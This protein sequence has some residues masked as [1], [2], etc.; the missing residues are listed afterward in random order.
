MTSTRYLGEESPETKYFFD[1][2]PERILAAAERFGVRCTGRVTQLNSMEN[3]VYEVEVELEAEPRTPSE[4]FR[5][6]KFY[7]PGRWSE[8]QILEEH[9]FLHDLQQAEIPAIA[10]T[11]AADGKTLL[12]FPDIKIWFSLFPKGGGRSPDELDDESTER[13]GRLLARMHTVGSGKDAPQRLRVT[14][15]VYGLQNV[16]YL[17]DSEVLPP[18][19]R[20]QYRAVVE[21]ICAF[22]EPL[23]KEVRPQRIHGDCHF[24]NILLGSLGMFL[25]DFDDMAVG[26]PVQDMWLLIPGRDP[27]AQRKLQVMLAGYEQLRPFDRGSIRLIEPL[28]ALRFVHYTA[29]VA[30]RWHDPAFQ[31]VFPDFGSSQYW[32]G[33]LSDLQDQWRVIQAGGFGV[34]ED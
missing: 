2:T 26:P 14:P 10:P 5:I 22:S 34:A 8:E 24:G 27:Y 32:R 29:W 25:V 9:Q 21:Q 16:Q 20:Q 31:R 1:L 7:R 12:S 4:R 30:R 18:E 15:A 13:L 3:R 17:I 11:P 19:I 28:R 23:F 33:Q 6:I